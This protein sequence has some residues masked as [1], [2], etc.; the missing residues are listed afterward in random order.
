M[1]SACV[2][3]FD[4]TSGA[5]WSGLHA[6]VATAS[7]NSTHTHDWSRSLL[8]P[9]SAVQTAVQVPVSRKAVTF[10][11][12]VSH[13]SHLACSLVFYY[14]R[15]MGSVAAAVISVLVSMAVVGCVLLIL[16][17]RSAA[18]TARA[19]AD[20]WLAV[21]AAEEAARRAGNAEQGGVGTASAARGALLTA[22]AGDE[23]VQPP[24]PPPPGDQRHVV[25]P[26]SVVTRS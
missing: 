4:V 21:G 24:P 10:W 16:L 5:V 8:C 13:L 12:R 3:D 15:A 14:R 6:S 17:Q 11:S 18:A 25:T 1:V 7:L 23:A 26:L 2:Y 22:F 9:E 19:R 20:H